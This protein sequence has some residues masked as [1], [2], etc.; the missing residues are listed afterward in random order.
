MRYN[1]QNC[2]TGKV[3][4]QYVYEAMWSIKKSFW[5]NEREQKPHRLYKCPFCGNYH[6]TS[7]PDNINKIINFYENNN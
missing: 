1:R 3:G 7:K 2:K 4:F 5:K 6:V